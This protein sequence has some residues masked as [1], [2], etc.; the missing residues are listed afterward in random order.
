MHDHMLESI[1][2]GFF[3]FEFRL[4]TY[5][6]DI[7]GKGTTRVHGCISFLYYCTHVTYSKHK[8]KKPNI[9]CM[10]VYVIYSFKEH[11]MLISTLHTPCTIIIRRILY[12]GVLL[13]AHVVHNT[14]MESSH[15]FPLLHCVT[16]GAH[17]V[18]K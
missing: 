18:Y 14:T 5:I 13:R 12:T 2:F 3:T 1:L 17:I 4:Y 10:F 7:I 11:K 15:T 9:R 8:C 6:Y 16:Y